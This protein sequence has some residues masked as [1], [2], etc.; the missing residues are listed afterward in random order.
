MNEP[1]V[2]VII[3]ALNME[4]YLG[5]A[6]SSIERQRHDRLEIIVV[7]A[8]S[9]DNTGAVVDKHR[10]DGLPVWLAGG[11]AMTPAAARNLGIELAKGKLIAFLDA[12]DLWPAGKLARQLGRLE[13]EPSVNMVSGYVTYFDVADKTGLNPSPESRTETLFHVHVGA[14]VYRREVFDRIGGPFDEDFLYSEDVDLMLRVRE[15]KIPFSILRSVELFYRLHPSSLMSQADPRKDASFRL[16]A[17]KSLMR[18]R[19]AGKLGTPLPDFA[20]YV[21][22]SP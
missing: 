11:S 13:S 6:L 17:H 22:R 1:T 9:T 2:S 3:P 20:N 7:D 10:R 12:D 18:R 14:C 15:Y 5:F 8:G 21:E 19:A 4:R 16:A